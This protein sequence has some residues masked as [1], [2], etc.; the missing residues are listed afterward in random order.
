MQKENTVHI[1]NFPL[2]IHI[3]HTTMNNMDIP[4]KTTVYFDGLC[5]L[6]SKEI[7]HYK[8][9]DHLKLID[10]VDICS[11]GF[12]AKKENLDPY[13]IHKIM[14]VRRQD[15]T[16]A[17]RV[18]AFVEIWKSIPK[19]HF[20]AR[21]A[22]FKAIKFLLEIFYSFFI[23]IRPL[24]PRYKKSLSCQNSPYCEINEVKNV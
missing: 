24:L 12:D 23:V 1:L 13:K 6:C 9:Q 22:E 7:N 2:T 18:D 8:K 16:V 10:F 11:D 4:Q 15:G 17:T 3:V 14:H 20:A 19:Y 21:I 5:K